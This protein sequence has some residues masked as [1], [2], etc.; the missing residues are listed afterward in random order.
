MLK[1]AKNCQ[2]FP[3]NFPKTAKTLKKSDFRLIIIYSVSFITIILFKLERFVDFAWGYRILTFHWTAIE[4]LKIVIHMIG[5]NDC[6]QLHYI[7]KKKLQLYTQ[8]KPQISL[9]FF[10]HKTSSDNSQ[11]NDNNEV[12]HFCWGFL[13]RITNEI[14]NEE[15]DHRLIDR[16]ELIPIW[17]YRINLYAKICEVPN[18]Q[19]NT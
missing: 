4:S 16:P 11:N 9:L 1:I 7:P 19:S 15:Y 17:K 2:K 3:K 12:F 6:G 10:T 5:I 8:K 14:V 13:I 18:E